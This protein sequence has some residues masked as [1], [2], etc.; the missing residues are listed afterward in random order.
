VFIFL[1]IAQS[2]PESMRNFSRII[3][4]TLFIVFLAPVA[5]KAMLWSFAEPRNWQ[6]ARWSSAGILPEAASLR[7][8]TLWT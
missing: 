7:A 1:A 3:R 5:T 4:L 2:Y 6:T 8:R